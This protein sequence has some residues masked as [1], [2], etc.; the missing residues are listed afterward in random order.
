MIGFAFFLPDP[1]LPDEPVAGKIVILKLE[2]AFAASPAGLLDEGAAFRA[3][4]IRKMGVRPVRLGQSAIAYM[5]NEA[6]FAKH[7]LP[8]LVLFLCG[9]DIPA[10]GC[11]IH[12]LPPWRS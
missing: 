8:G 12:V 5:V 7:P 11:A 9:S 3:F 1:G 6:G 10:A 4:R 2:I